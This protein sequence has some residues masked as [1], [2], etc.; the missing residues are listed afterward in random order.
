MKNFIN[1]MKETAT[2]SAEYNNSIT[3]NGAL[4]YE[5]TGKALLDLNFEVSSLRNEDEDYI[6]KEFVKAYSENPSLAITW[7]FYVRDVRE[8]LGERRLFRVCSKYLFSTCNFSFEQIN[9]YLHFIS[10]YGRWDDLYSLVG[11]SK[12]IDT[13]IT[14]VISNQLEEDIINYSNKKPISLLAKWLKSEKASSEESRILAKWTREQLGMSPKQYRQTLSALRTYIDVT[15]VKMC[16][17]R[18]DE[19]DYSTVPSKASLNYKQA[20]KRH[21]EERYTEFIAKVNK[22]EAKINASTLFPHDIVHKYSCENNWWNIKTKDLDESLEALWKNLHNTVNGNSSTLVVADSSGSM[23]ANINNTSCTPFEIAH[24]LAIYFAERASGPYKDKYITFS[25]TP[26]FIDLSNCDTLKAKLDTAYAHS[27]V[28]NTDIEKVFDLILETAINNKCKQ[29]DIPANIL[30]IS[31][32]EFD[33]A[34]EC[35]VDE[36][37]FK[38]I[39]NKYKAAGY[40]LPRLVFWNINSRTKTLP[41]IQNELGIALVSGYSPNIAK[42]VMDNEVDPYKCLLKVLTS[43]RYKQVLDTFKK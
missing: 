19:I 40:K 13:L 18:W 39:E 32:M 9:K 3:E 7:L 14:T 30:I 8:G 16:D 17:N 36:T 37:L 11:V 24:A 41:V 28:A 31:D 42:M 4:G 33:D 26:R 15:E 27:E 10:E 23:I 38:T 5:T 6:V 20:F 35:D 29:E 25:D 12:E 43:D 1:Q 34:T 2:N 22:G 21:D